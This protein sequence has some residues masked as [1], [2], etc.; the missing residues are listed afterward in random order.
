MPTPLLPVRRDHDEARRAY[1]RLAPWYEALAGAYEAPLRRAALARSRVA[2]G[3][4]VLELGFGTGTLLLPLAEAV[5]SGEVFALDLSE[6]MHAQ[7]R[8]RLARN[9][10]AARVRLLLGDAIAIP[11]GDAQVDAALM[12]FTLELFDVPELPVV[13]AELRRVLRPGG[14]LAVAA[15]S[16]EGGIAWIR[17][18][19]AW[20]H[21]H[22]ERWADCRPIPTVR[23][24]SEA[25]F[26]VIEAEKRTVWGLPVDL[27]TAR[28]GAD[29]G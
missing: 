23:L 25:G 6:G 17:G 22:F 12:T 19:Y 18:L 29:P 3:E 13:L 24:L 26:E 8:A 28:A 9:P 11:L 7:A 4:R 10:L 2:A 14:R 1:D 5:G 27:V 15:L 21:L 16:D 20:V